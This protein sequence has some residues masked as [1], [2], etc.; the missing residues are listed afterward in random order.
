KPEGPGSGM[1]ALRQAAPRKRSE[2]YSFRLLAR[3]EV[4]LKFR[5]PSPRCI[6][7]TILSSEIGFA[8]SRA[9]PELGLVPNVAIKALDASSVSGSV[10][11]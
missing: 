2:V 4:Y 7:L 8:K 11:Q 3:L 6:A 1:S 10:V 5:L 9:P